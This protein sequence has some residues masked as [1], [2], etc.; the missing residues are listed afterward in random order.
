[1]N[2]VSEAT[3]AAGAGHAHVP[4]PAATAASLA[5]DIGPGRGALII[6][7]SERYRG[8]EIE[9]VKLSDESVRTHTGVHPRSTL[10]GSM[11]TAVFGSLSPGQYLVAEG[12]AAVT[13]TEGA[14][15][16]LRL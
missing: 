2:A 14:V 5:L 4:G 7:P 16:E 13:I 9:I 10:K 11:L 8:Q 3:T 12:E 1:M 15:T 6:Y